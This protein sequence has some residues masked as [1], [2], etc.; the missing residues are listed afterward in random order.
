[1]APAIVDEEAAEVVFDALELAAVEAVAS[2]G[3]RTS[4]VDGG[5][6]SVDGREIVMATLSAITGDAAALLVADVVVALVASP[7]S[8]ARN[9][10]P[11][12]EVSGAS[13]REPPPPA[14][15]T[16]SKLDC[17]RGATPSDASL[18]M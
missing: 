1:M 6:A 7:A 12:P 3:T 9:C 2:G 10:E 5:L 14:C 8:L 17:D 18:P 16:V 13:G 15:D 11:L 4:A